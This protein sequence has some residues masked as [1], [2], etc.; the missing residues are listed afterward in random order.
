MRL[1]HLARASSERS[2]ERAGVR[3]RKWIVDVG[4]RR[5]EI[6]R[7]VFAM[8][9]LADWSTTF[10]WLRE[11][12][13]WHDERMVAVHLRVPDDEAVL[14]G[15]YG[16]AHRRVSAVAASRWVREHSAGAEIIVPRAVP[17]RDV[18]AIRRMPQL[19]GWTETPDAAHRRSCICA[20]CLPVGVPGRIRQ[21]RVEYTRAVTVLRRSKDGKA[22]ASAVWEMEKALE[23]A[24][25]RLDHAPLERFARDG[26]PIVRELVTSLL[27]FVPLRVAQPALLERLEDDCSDV[28]KAAAE[29]LVRKLGPV[30]SAKIAWSHAEV[31]EAIGADLEWRERTPELDALAARVAEICR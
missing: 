20:R 2:I 27:R 21:I 16:A 18:L 15:R 12:R 7:G 24:P 30:R 17:R 23:S 31:V 10:Q 9:V 29:T 14:V 6:A 8:P 25:G 11:L 4:G 1:V 13:R 22:R 19:V 5:E 3:G 26:D 28:R